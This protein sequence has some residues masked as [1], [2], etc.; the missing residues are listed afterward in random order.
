MGVRCDADAH[1]FIFG[2]K[3][4]EASGTGG[5]PIGARTA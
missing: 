5:A 1:V 4:I 3:D 2:G